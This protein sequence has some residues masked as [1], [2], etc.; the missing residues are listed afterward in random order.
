MAEQQ[1]SKTVTTPV[2]YKEG[3]GWKVQPGYHDETGREKKRVRE[4]IIAVTKDAK[5][6]RVLQVVDLGP[7]IVTDVGDRYYAQCG[8]RTEAVTHTFNIGN[9]V[10]ANGAT[11]T[12]A[13]G[14]KNTATFGRFSGLGGT[15]TGR[16]SF[17]SGY[18]KTADSDTDNTG[19]T[20]DAV[21]YKR[22]YSTSQA[23]YTIKALGICKNGAT[24]NSSGALLS[25]KTLTSAQ[26]IQK[27]GSM[28]LTVYINHTFLGV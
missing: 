12:I 13:G 19:R 10:V 24:T 18:P 4:T 5:T 14:A 27:T 28:T 17:T 15:Y 9:M 1:D 20:I 6:G 23:N 2:Y 16:Q 26:F 22:V 21:T 7:N 25:F 8:T 11:V 3:E